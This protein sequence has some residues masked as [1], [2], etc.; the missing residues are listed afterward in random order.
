MSKITSEPQV[1][2]ENNFN[3][4]LLE[5]SGPYQFLQFCSWTLHANTE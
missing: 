1:Q 2:P 3:E 5:G 4:L